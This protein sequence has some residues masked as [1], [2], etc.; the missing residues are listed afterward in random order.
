MD[1][2][3]SV[4]L[5][6]D[7]MVWLHPAHHWSARGLGDRRMALWGGFVIKT[8]VATIYVSGDTGYGDGQIFKDVRTSYGC[9][10]LAILP[11][12]AYEP[13]W[14]MKNQHVDPAEAVQIMLD[15]G[16]RQALGIHW[17]TFPLADEPA[18]AAPRL[19]QEEL[20]RR[21]LPASRFVALDAGDLWRPGA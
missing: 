13:R 10:D 19:L 9:P 17:G 18:L 14:F 7:V 5:G 21:G 20:A 8:P 1:W 3:Q 4:A 2:R 15:C 12:G 11:I 6:H 16:A